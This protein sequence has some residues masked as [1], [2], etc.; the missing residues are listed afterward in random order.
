MVSAS[1]VI[2]R[3]RQLFPKHVEYE[4]DIARLIYLK[5]FV[6]S[7]ENETRRQILSLIAKGVN[8]AS[9]IA[10]NI[11]TARTAIYRHLNI[12]KKNGFIEHINN[13]YY[14][15]ARIFL[16]YDVIVSN[17]SVNIV[18]L[19]DYGA[20]ADEEIGFIV[21]R[22]PQCMCDVCDI[23]EQ[24]LAGVKRLAKKLDIKLRSET[25]IKAFQEIMSML[26]ERDITTILKK[27]LLV[28]KPIVEEVE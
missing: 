3:V 24:C 27:S 20:F 5:I 25:P 7:L 2:E 8:S 28:L 9:E 22:G 15:S 13:R 18:I 10:S 17:G 26:I 16:A 6:S 12:L 14:L 4:P 23:R 11:G 21:I 1:S 19:T